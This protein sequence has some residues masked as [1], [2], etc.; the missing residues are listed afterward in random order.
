MAENILARHGQANSTATDE[1]GYEMEVI[2]PAAPNVIMS[3][4]STTPVRNY[5]GNP[6]QNEITAVIQLE[7]GKT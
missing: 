5:N 6:A 3:T 1:A 4:I 7:A 2:N